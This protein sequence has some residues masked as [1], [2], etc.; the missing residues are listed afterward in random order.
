MQSRS[1]DPATSKMESFTIITAKLSTLDVFKVPA[2]NSVISRPQIQQCY[3]SEWTFLE[4]IK[5]K[6]NKIY[7]A[8]ITWILTERILRK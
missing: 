2:Y 4:V 6:G 5:K 3:D 7:G 1:Q 8:A